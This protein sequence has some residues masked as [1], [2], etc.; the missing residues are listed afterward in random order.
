MK[1]N[2]KNLLFYLMM[3]CCCLEVAFRIMGYEPW[4]NDDYSVVAQPENAYVGHQDLGI[5]NN[6]GTYRITMNEGLV[7]NTRHLEDN[8]RYVGAGPDTAVKDV[9]MLGCSFTYGFGVNDDQPFTSLLQQQFPEVSFQNAGVIGYGTVQSLLQ[10]KELVKNQHPKVVILDISS[11]HF[12]RNTL[13]PQYRSNLKIGYGRS[14]HRV[15]NQMS[16][17]RFPYKSSCADTIQYAPWKNIYQSWPGREWLATINWFQTLYDLSRE[18]VGR[19]IE[20]TACLIREMES[21]CRANAIRFGVACLDSSPETNALK[22]RLLPQ[23]PWVDVNFDFSNQ[24]WINHPY[25]T[26]PNPTGHQ[27]IAT[28][29]V[30]LLNTLLDEK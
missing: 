13:S 12:M 21:I 30:P 10:L 22:E 18:E 17:A 2:L 24:Q 3:A 29:I 11:F 20:V 26:H 1:I 9:V 19:Q 16:K 25:D 23:M 4:K 6:P 27:Y 28:S 7:F 15:D 5:L 8:T 14:S